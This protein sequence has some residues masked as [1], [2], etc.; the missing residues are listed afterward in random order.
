MK[1]VQLLNRKSIWTYY[2]ENDL[3]IFYNFTFIYLKHLDSYIEYLA[4]LGTNSYDLCSEIG[5]MIIPITP[6]DKIICN[7][8]NLYVIK[9]ET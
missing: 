9:D 6:Q 8:C 3:I 4:K 2:I 7:Y 5:I 1:R